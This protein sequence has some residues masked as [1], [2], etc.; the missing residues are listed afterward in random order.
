[1]TEWDK[2]LPQVVGAYNS[3][4]H[5]TTGIGPFKMQ[6]GRQRAMA[7]A[8]F[9]L[10][11]GGQK[12]SPQAYVKE[13]VKRQQELNELCIRNTAQA[14]MKQRR[15]CDEKILQAKPYT[16]GKYVWVFQNV[17]HPKGTKKLLKKWR[18]PFMVTEV[19]QQGRFYRLSTGC[20][21]HYEK[22]RPHVP[23]P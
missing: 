12:T 19:H 1:M 23:S 6:T 2:Y 11:Y 22:M 5:S 16:V 20:A 9:Y 17:I 8:F 10:E 21:E 7:L 18:D 14:Q 4:Q 3:T 15:N 13:A